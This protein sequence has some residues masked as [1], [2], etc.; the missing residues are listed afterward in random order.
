MI[1]SMTQISRGGVGNVSI[2]ADLGGPPPTPD[3]SSQL[4]IAIM[5]LVGDNDAALR[6]LHRTPV[7][8]RTEGIP[9][10][11]LMKQDRSCIER[12]ELSQLPTKRDSRWDV[13]CVKASKRRR[14]G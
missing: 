4:Y 10:H 7:H 1:H 6:S 12:G 8:L 9:D 13:P 2:M 14:A 5:A 3:L 11:L